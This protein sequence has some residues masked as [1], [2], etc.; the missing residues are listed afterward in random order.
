MLHPRDCEQPVEVIDVRTPATA[1][2]VLDTLV[3]VD[4]TTRTDDLV[5]PS[6]VMEELPAV[7][8]KCTQIGIDRLRMRINKVML[9]MN[10]PRRTSDWPGLTSSPRAIRDEL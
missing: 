3:V 8:D 1:R 9:G 2:E 4:A 10:Y 6:D 7:P 5:C